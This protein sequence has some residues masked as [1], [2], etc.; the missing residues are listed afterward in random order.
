V[1]S[2]LYFLGYG[3]AILPSTFVTIKHGARRWVGAMTLVTGM[4]NSLVVVVAG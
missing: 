4:H 1:G 2:G 3:L